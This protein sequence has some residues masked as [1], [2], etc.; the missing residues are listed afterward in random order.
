MA[1]HEVIGRSSI[2]FCHPVLKPFQ[3]FSCILAI[4]QVKLIFAGI[5]LYW[6]KLEK[7]DVRR[8]MG[9]T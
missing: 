7:R 2:F 5:D 6:K 8:E 9:S 3:Y 1:R 4:L